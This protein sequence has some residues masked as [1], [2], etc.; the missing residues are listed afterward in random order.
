M[1]EVEEPE[2]AVPIGTQDHDSEAPLWSPAGILA[3]YDSTL[4][5]VILV[6]PRQGAEPTPINLIP[7]GL[8]LQGS[9]S[10]DGTSLVL[11]EILFPIDENAVSEE[12]HSE[13]D[14]GPDFFSHLIM[15]NAL[16]AAER[17]LSGEALGLV[18]DAFAAISPDG[19][20]IAFAR[21]YLD[22][23]WTPGRQ[24]W[25]MGTDGNQAAARTSK[26]DYHHSAFA[27]SP[28]STQIAYMRFNQTDPSQSPEIWV[29]DLERETSRLLLKGGY[30]P[31]WIP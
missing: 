8:G 3:F 17:D 27:W 16:T 21:K 9:W 14:E 20:W 28:D 12:G 25:I 19:Q 29:L 24:L 31:Q 4:R 13:A 6:D 11:P 1:L 15:V 30:L 7:N 22:E 10:P 5:A 18:E 23:R 26:P 2:E